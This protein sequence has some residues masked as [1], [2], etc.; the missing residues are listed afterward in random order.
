MF[1]KEIKS[2]QKSSYMRMEI[3]L[4]SHFFEHIIVVNTDEW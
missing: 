1:T 4:K 3:K 2:L